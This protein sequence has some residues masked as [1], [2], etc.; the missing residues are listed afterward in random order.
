VKTNTPTEKKKRSPSKKAV[1]DIEDIKNDSGV[2]IIF[3]KQ[4]NKSIIKEKDDR[5]IGMN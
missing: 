1:I 3:N 2:P 4:P 5:N